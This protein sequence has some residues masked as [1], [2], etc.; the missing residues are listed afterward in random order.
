MKR[1]DSFHGLLFISKSYHW[2]VVVSLRYSRRLTYVI[3]VVWRDK[4]AE[5]LTL[6]YVDGIHLLLSHVFPASV[7]HFTRNHNSTAVSHLFDFLIPFG[8]V[9]FVYRY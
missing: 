4:F 1:L 9:S 7:A 3:Y 6:A 2:V 5:T 8:S